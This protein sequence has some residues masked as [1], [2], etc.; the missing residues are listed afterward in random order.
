MRC[1]N[2]K[3]DKIYTPFCPLCGRVLSKHP[4]L[5]L[6]L[7]CRIQ[8]GKIEKW[9]E[10]L[11]DRKSQE[12]E[13]KTLAKWKGWVESLEEVIEA[14]QIGDEDDNLPTPNDVLG[15]MSDENKK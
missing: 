1:P 8:L 2:C 9:M 6:L 12:S 7:H 15:I 13:D 5:S 10:S 11:G 14:N 4:L 3:Q